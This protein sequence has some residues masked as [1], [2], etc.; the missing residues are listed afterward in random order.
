[1]RSIRLITTDP[2][3]TA[4][5]G[6]TKVVVRRLASYSDLVMAL[7]T[8]LE[9]LAEVAVFADGYSGEKL[10]ELA[11]LAESSSGDML[12][13]PGWAAVNFNDPGTVISLAS[14]IKAVR[15]GAS[16]A[17]ESKFTLSN[18]SSPQ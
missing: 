10:E 17:G 12:L 9:D 18:Q 2:Q 4:P 14:E 13:G 6:W 1:M 16:L 5:V 8:A 7:N 11:A 15:S 3:R